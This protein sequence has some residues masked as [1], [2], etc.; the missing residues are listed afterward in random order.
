M[1]ATMSLGGG[2]GRPV[3]HELARMGR[4]GGEGGRPQ[5]DRQGA[6][7]ARDKKDAVGAL[8]VAVQF[9]HGQLL[10]LCR[11]LADVLSIAQSVGERTTQSSRVS[12]S[13]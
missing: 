10:K 1:G 9:A 8:H 12:A 7:L 4:R 2:R 3:R 5:R 6:K 11:S 13:S